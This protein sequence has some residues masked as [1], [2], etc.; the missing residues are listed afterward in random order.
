MRGLGRVWPDGVRRRRANPSDA[1]DGG[2]R[3][4]SLGGISAGPSHVGSS[5]RTSVPELPW[6]I[7]YAASSAPIAASP[8]V[9][10]TNRA[11][12]SA[13][14]FIG[15]SR[16]LDRL[17]LLRTGEVCSHVT[18]ALRMN[19]GMSPCVTPSMVRALPRCDRAAA[20]RLP[21][22][23]RRRCRSAWAGRL[24]TWSDPRV[25]WARGLRRSSL[26]RSRASWEWFCR[27]SPTAV[28]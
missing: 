13:L 10:S 21:W 19:H 11:A 7:S 22:T 27:G 23:S 15:T 1:A 17:D 14:G 28:R 3:L 16:A 9:R 6:T 26:L 2:D 5:G 25:R 4:P 8:P 18:A 24:S 12:A 20:R